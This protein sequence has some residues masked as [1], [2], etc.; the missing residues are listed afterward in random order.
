MP[1][2]TSVTHLKEYITAGQ[3]SDAYKTQRPFTGAGALLLDLFKEDALP[4]RW[5]KL[6]DFDLTLDGLLVLARPN[7]VVRLGRFQL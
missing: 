3:S 1:D 7:N 4:E 2:V 6:G 5:V